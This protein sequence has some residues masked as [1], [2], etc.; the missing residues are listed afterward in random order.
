[1]RLRYGRIVKLTT[2][3]KTDCPK[4]GYNEITQSGFD[5][6]C[7]TCKGAGKVSQIAVESLLCRVV[8]Q[9]LSISMGLS[10][11]ME[12]GDCYFFVNADEEEA[13]RAADKIEIDGREVIPV[14]YHPI[15]TP[16]GLIGAIRVTCEVKRG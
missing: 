8:W 9:P 4:C 3:A 6:A 16:H 14:R 5:S 2:A 12:A 10:G 7:P 11:T 1:M 13:I 15:V